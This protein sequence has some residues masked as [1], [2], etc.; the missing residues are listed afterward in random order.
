M[1]KIGGYAAAAIM[2]LLACT[3]SAA[4]TTATEPA[5]AVAQIQRA[6]VQSDM[7]DELRP[8]LT[9]LKASD[10]ELMREAYAACANLLF[11]DKDEYREAV[12]KEYPD[13]KLAVDHL[14][15]AAA[16][17]KHLCAG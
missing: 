17:K 13:V 10:A 3:A 8:Y 16:A 14:T 15:V 5:K 7:L 2:A 9:T 6:S 1:G 11:R 12:L 4:P